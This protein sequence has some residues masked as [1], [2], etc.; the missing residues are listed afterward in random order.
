[1]IKR[2]LFATA[3][4]A[5]A[6]TTD[7]AAAK[8]K[9]AVATY[10]I[11]HAAGVDGRLDLRRIAA[12]IRATK[13]DVIGLQEVDRHFDA[14]SEFV[15]QAQRL[16]RLLDMDVVYGANLDLE[17]Y[18]PGQPRRQYGTAILSKFPI[19]S[20]RNTLLPRPEGGEQRGLLE[21]VIRANK[22]RVRIANTH[23]QHTSATERSA[24]VARILELLEA[25]DEPT[26]LVGDLNATP[27]AAELQPLFTRF[28]D[29]WPL[30]GQGDG[31]T[32]PAEA[33]DRRIDY[34]LVT[35]EIDVRSAEVRS[36]LASD[37]LPVTAKLTIEERPRELAATTFNAPRAAE[38]KFAFSASAPNTDW[39]RR[40]LE[41]AVVTVLL[42]GEPTQD[43]VL[44]A[45]A[46]PFTYKVALGRVGAGRHKVS[47][48]LNRRSSPP[49]VGPV[50]TG[51]L[52]TQLAAAGD[53][54]ARHAPIL[55]G[56]D[57]PEIAGRWENARTDVPMLAYHATAAAGRRHAHDRVHGDLVQRGRRDEL[58]G[59]DGAL[60]PH[61]R[62]RV[63]LPRARRRGR[64]RPR[65]RLSRSQPRGAA[66][67][68]CQGERSSSAPD[69][70]L[71]QQPAAGRRS[72]R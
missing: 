5:V 11:H 50:N 68:R 66:V 33:P 9:L 24:Q 58:P 20:S 27:E 65:R 42:D 45:G 4:A 26:V 13:A 47:L 21:A 8:P 10:N 44:Y 63:D 53:L 32:I 51:N 41:A 56:R 43:V 31:F 71:E 29:A 69:R 1:M 19:V 35:P 16:S 6:L 55:Y 12:E 15:D 37:H 23:L 2:A 57:L 30:G 14:R 54:V 28:D 62:H 3:L 70:D 36:T 60:G 48:R 34:V 46:R 39:S 17:P 25:A 59:A 61:D 22:T 52:R 72:S 67:H 38:A 7:A 18:N 49:A 64:Q 40:G